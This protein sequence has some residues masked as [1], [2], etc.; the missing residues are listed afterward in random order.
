MALFERIRR[1]G[2]LVGRWTLRLQKPKPDPVSLSLSLQPLDLDIDFS[3]TIPA[4]MLP[5]SP[6]WEDNGLNL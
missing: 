2:L 4:Y 1:C 5:C 6:S 3:A